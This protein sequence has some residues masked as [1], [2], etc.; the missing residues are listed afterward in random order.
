MVASTTLARVIIIIIKNKNI[1][2]TINKMPV[3][4]LLPLLRAVHP[5]PSALGFAPGSTGVSVK[6]V[7]N[8]K[9]NEKERMVVGV[10][11]RPGC[12]EGV[13]TGVRRR[14][15]DRGTR[16]TVRPPVLRGLQSTLSLGPAYFDGVRLFSLPFHRGPGCVAA[17]Q[18]LAGGESRAAT[19]PPL[20]RNRSG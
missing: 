11:S 4:D 16:L 14:H 19:V 7:A 12:V 8:A 6:N 17:C 20:P 9:G 2:I 1:M 18:H 10:G 15:R 3:D 5:S 13:D